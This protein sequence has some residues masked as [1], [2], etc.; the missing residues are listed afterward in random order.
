MNTVLG[1]DF[2]NTI[3]CYDEIF[4]RVAREQELI[5]PDTP[6]TKEAVRNYLRGCDREDVWTELQGYVYGGRMHDVDPYPGVREFIARTVRQG[7][8]VYIISHKTRYPYLGHPYDLHGAALDWLEFQGFFASDRIGMPRDRV[9]FELTREEK[10]ARIG[11][12]GCSHFIDDLPEFL[13][14]ETFPPAT[15][16]FLFA[17]EDPDNLDRYR[18]AVDRTFRSWGEIG[19]YFSRCG[20]GE[21]CSD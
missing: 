15:A 9:F 6:V 2:D 18:N 4:H 13:A 20:K 8:P 19:A 5:P 12:I 3:V 10:L 7:L 16:R 17:P 14:E 11:T 1:I 21:S